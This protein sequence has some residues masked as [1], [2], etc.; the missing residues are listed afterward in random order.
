M[1]EDNTR[2][3]SVAELLA[4]NGTIGS[5]PVGGHRRRK[6]PN[7]VSVAELTGEI[8]VIRN[9]GIPQVDAYEPAEAY[10]QEDFDQQE[11]FY[12]QEDVYEQEDFHE[13]EDLLAEPARAASSDSVTVQ[14][15]PA[16][17][18]RSE[19]YGQAQVATAP[20][21]A[22]YPDYSDYHDYTPGHLAAPAGDVSSEHTVSSEYDVSSGNNVSSEYGEV[23]YLQ[24]VGSA[25]TAPIG[26]EPVPDVTPEVVPEPGVEPARPPLSSIP[27]PRRRRG[28][29][30]SH[31]PRPHRQ[32]P[33]H[34]RASGAEQMSPDPVDESADFAELVGENAADE[35]DLRSYLRAST[36]TLFFGETMADD[37]ARRG[38]FRDRADGNERD[39]V[40]ADSV[41]APDRGR[42]GGLRT[43]SVA[44][45]Q[46]L[47]AVVS[48]AALFVAFDQLWRWNNTVAL[49]LSALVIAALM[50][51][52]R[53]VRK[54]EDF[55]S[56]LI[57]A[58]VGILVTIGPLALQS[59]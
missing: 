1:T 52:V 56:I 7:S 16:G 34:E 44:V 29:E 3:V 36:P 45:L 28:L 37:L 58:L 42:L 9:G 18:S 22:D 10:E 8:P 25:E 46:S 5:P 21:Y 41:E 55:T 59:T 11:D 38:D 35:A 26:P 33:D 17:D 23:S 4:R 50:T 32:S 6:R 39:E 40:A 49:A 12:K 27:L 48:G 31:D 53:A 57:A 47:L 54:S 51:G 13:Q 19:A 2:P 20:A 43:S 14:A 15:L 24:T 30:R